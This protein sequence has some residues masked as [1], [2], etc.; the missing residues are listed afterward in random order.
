[1][2]S[3]DAN[4]TLFGDALP[5]KLGHASV[6]GIRA[7]GILTKATGFMGAYDFTLNPYSGCSFG[8]TY[9]YAAFFARDKS[10]QEDWGK[11]IKVKENAVDLLRRRRTPLRGKTIYMSSVTD[12]YQPIE[13]R[14]ELVRELLTQLVRHQP[15]LVIQ[16]RSDLVTRD[17]DLLKQFDNV[18]VNMTVTTDSEQVRKVFEPY[19]PSL[20]RR[21]S[22]IAAVQN[23]GISTCI[24]MTPLLPIED[25]EAFAND[26]RATHVKRFVVQ[27]FHSDRGKFVAST[28]EPAQ[29]LISEMRWDDHA[30]RAVVEKLR[31]TL[32]SLREGKEGFSPECPRSIPGSGNRQAHW[33]ASSPQPAR[34]NST[35]TPSGRHSRLTRRSMISGSSAGEVTAATTDPR[36]ARPTLS[37]ITGV[38]PKTCCAYCAGGATKPIL[39]S[40]RS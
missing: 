23:A 39:R 29:Q 17:I 3:Q 1:M 34:Q 11:W 19:C 33:T 2:P 15:R 35:G 25:P 26:L 8:C 16:T 21:L 27:P 14:V 38:A 7:S 28:R 10:L 32:P 13:Q 22:G 18:R 20:A 40:G 31:S 30:Y 4:L 9:C 36:L 6:E 5:Q 12:P 37:G 24:T